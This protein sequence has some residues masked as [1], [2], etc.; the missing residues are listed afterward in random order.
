[1]YFNELDTRESKDI[2]PGIHMRTFWGDKMLI[3]VVDIER[4]ATV[5][6]H[7]HPHEQ[8][9]TVISGQMALTIAGETRLLEPGDS[10]I[11]PGGV[12]HSATSGDGPA[13]VIDVFSPVRE[14][15]QY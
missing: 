2:A 10:Y 3:S 9:G 7:S 11:I 14:E 5:P 1:M 13:R 8:C 4:G 12:E 6:T 15:Y